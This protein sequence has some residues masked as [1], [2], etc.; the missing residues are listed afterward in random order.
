MIDGRERARATAAAAAPP[1][2]S[3]KVYVL[4]LNCIVLL[5]GFVVGGCSHDIDGRG[6][7]SDPPP[8]YCHSLL[9]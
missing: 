1:T 6:W 2:A 5:C 4:S 9:P 7:K 8:I 3:T